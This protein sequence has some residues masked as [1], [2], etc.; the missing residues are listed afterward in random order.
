MPLLLLS[1]CLSGTFGLEFN[2]LGLLYSCILL[3]TG[4]VF[5]ILLSHTHTPLLEA[6]T[7]AQQIKAL[8][9][10]VKLPAQT[11]RYIT[12]HIASSTGSDAL[13]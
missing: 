4:F 2:N 7:I 13:S 12:A 6:G 10:A 3:E 8:A 1:D 9:L 11:W 5:L